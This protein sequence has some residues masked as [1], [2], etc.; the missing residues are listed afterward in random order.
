MRVYSTSL[1]TVY[2]FGYSSDISKCYL[3]IL[4]DKLTTNLRLMVWYKNPKDKEGIIIYRRNTMDF[5]DAAS[6]LIVRIIQKMFL[7]PMARLEATRHTIMAGGV[8]TLTII[9]TALKL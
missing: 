5:G 1:C 8:G 7:S 6:A 9:Q 3:R 4:V 2:R